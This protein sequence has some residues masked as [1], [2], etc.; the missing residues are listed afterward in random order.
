MLKERLI[1]LRN[2][3]NLTKTQVAKFLNISPEG[4]SYYEKGT[5]TPSIETI[6]RLSTFYGVSTDYL[7]GKTDSIQKVRK[8]GVKIP[9]IGNVIAGVPIEAIEE[10]ID[11]EEIT[12]EMASQGD[13]FGLVIKGD[14]MEPRICGGDV[15]I[16][17]KQPDVDSGSLAIVLINGNEATVKKIIKQ[18]SGIS[19]VPFNQNY[20]PKFFTNEE[21][22]SLPLR[23]LGKV[24]ELRGKF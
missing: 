24:V 7:L 9:V 15:V 5:R 3:K 6:K 18:S 11:Y 14:S 20:S 10:I 17:R 22:K 21:I 1:E 8:K 16:I 4:Y 23:I 2:G 12:E 13:H 19:L